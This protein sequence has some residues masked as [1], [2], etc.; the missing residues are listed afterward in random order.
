MVS[1]LFVAS[2]G[3]ANV[4]RL[5]RE[6]PLGAKCAHLA[7]QAC[8]RIALPAAFRFFIFSPRIQPAEQIALLVWIRAV[9]LKN[10]HDFRQLKC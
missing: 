8:V 5:T 2:D 10:C 6:E 9:K 7:L 1:P 4:V 3:L